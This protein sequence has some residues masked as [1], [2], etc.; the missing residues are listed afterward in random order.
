MKAFTVGLLMVG[1]ALGTI[2]CPTDD[3]V[4][5]DPNELVPPVSCDDDGA[6]ISL[7]RI[8]A[9][10]RLGSPGWLQVCTLC[11]S[12]AIELTAGVPLLA[13][14]TGGFGCA[15]AFPMEAPPPGDELT[16]DVVVRSAQRTGAVS[17]DVPLPGGRGENPETLGTATWL[18]DLG[19]P[20]AQRIPVGPFD[21]VAPA[22]PLP[23]LLLHLG[24]PDEDGGRT[25]TLGITEPGEVTQ[26]LCATTVQWSLPATL[27]QR[28]LTA[29]LAPGDRLPRPLGGPV[30]AGVLQARISS[31]GSALTS[32][33]ILTQLDLAAWEGEVG[34]PPNELCDLLAE[35]RGSEVCVPC[36]D[37][38]DGTA[39]LPTCITNVQEFDLAPSSTQPLLPVIAGELPPDCL[40]A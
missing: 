27:D 20:E 23:G 19:N 33:S 21:V 35:L 38:A 13:A 7:T 1:L 10:S 15:V 11:P 26:D 36:T 32:G 3:P 39:G 30:L 34:L 16:V 37:P 22:E 31:S 9:D 14:W 18:I 40:E 8:D 17:I 6:P 4:P 25:V 5:P 29:L 2:G 12:T 28:H 24:D